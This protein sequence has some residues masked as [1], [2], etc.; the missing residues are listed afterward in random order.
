MRIFKKS[1]KD[2]D[3]KEKHYQKW[4]VEISDH[5][6]KGRRFS[7]YKDKRATE[8]LG[9]KIEKLVRCKKLN[10]A[11]PVELAKWIEACPRTLKEHLLKIGLLNAQETQ[12]GKPL[13]ALFS[14]FIESRKLRG[15]VK[16][17]IDDIETR[18]GRFFKEKNLRYWT[19]VDSQ[20]IEKYLA[21]IKNSGRSAR[22]VNVSLQHFRAFH[23]WMLDNELI[24]RPLPGLRKIKKL[25]ER[26]DRRK[27]RRSL[28][29]DELRALLQAAKTRPLAEA[30]RINRGQDKGKPGAKLAPETIDKLKLLGLER[31]LVYETA[32]YTGL[33][34][35][36][37]GSIS[38][39][40]VLLNCPAPRIILKPENE[41][42]RRGCELPLRKD[43]AAEIKNY[44]KRKGL[45]P[46][47]KLFVLPN[48]RTF[49]RDLTLAGVDYK[50][51][52]DGR[53]VDFHGLRTSFAT[54]LSK[55][56]VHPRIAQAAL[57]HSDIRLTMAIYT[58]PRLLDVSGAIDTLPGLS[59]KKRQTKTA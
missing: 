18:L 49:K 2:E 56:G 41:K 37:L 6:G 35:S 15:C 45:A 48:L 54:H 14:E 31:A 23:N 43:L 28:T 33:R 13:M 30:E 36:E 8:S 59:D 5:R 47:D 25:D 9:Q 19:D 39:R 32:F 29:I 38:V 4:Y 12:A 44:I 10:E 53:S 22:I 34:R 26:Q 50:K 57:R 17:Y 52:E 40:D 24:T 27:I 16:Q 3:G 58:D 20:K 55:S 7:G 42:A 1:Y 11:L 51:D 46:K 21:E